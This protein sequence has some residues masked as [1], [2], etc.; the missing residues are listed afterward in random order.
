MKAKDGDKVK[1]HYTGTLDDGSVFDSS[2]E[3]DP[4]AFTLG[5]GQILKGFEEGVIGLSIGESTKVQ[6]SAAEG[7]GLKREELIS[8]V[9]RDLLPKEIDPKVGMKLQSQSKDGKTFLVTVTEVNDQEIT[10]DANHELA[11][12]DLNFNIELVEIMS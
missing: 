5:K 12:K 2:R 10:V 9:S 1:V 8:Q 7:Y 11:G 6:I 3:R 4:L